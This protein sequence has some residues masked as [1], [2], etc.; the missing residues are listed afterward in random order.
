MEGT[1]PLRVQ[2]HTGEVK[3]APG[4]GGMSSS[5]LEYLVRTLSV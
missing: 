1:E 3:P 5:P 2:K 4:V